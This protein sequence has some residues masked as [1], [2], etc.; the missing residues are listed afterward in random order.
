M[1]VTWDQV[2]WA[3]GLFLVWNGFLVGVI[4]WL[5]D[6]HLALAE[7]QIR[8][9]RED[10]KE[11]NDRF[12]KFHADLPVQY[13]RQ[14]HCR[15]C[16]EEFLRHIMVLDRKFDEFTGKVFAKLD[17]FRKEVYEQRAR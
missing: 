5:I 11:L 16:R 10:L 17:D 14:E 1:N 4:K 12:A 9:M 8:A 15:A 7:E 2:C 3:A 13:I 6:R